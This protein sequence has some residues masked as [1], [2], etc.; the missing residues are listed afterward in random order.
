[1]EAVSLATALSRIDSCEYRAFVRRVL[2]GSDAAAAERLLVKGPVQ[3]RGSPCTLVAAVDM[4]CTRQAYGQPRGGIDVAAARAFD[5]ASRTEVVL[6][7]LDDWDD[8]MVRGGIRFANVIPRGTLVQFVV[9]GP[10]GAHIDAV[11]L[12]ESLYTVVS[13]KEPDSP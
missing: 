3:I 5:S 11:D 12:A 2:V 6:S 13:V 7:I 1:M 10:P 4:E 9:L 8:D